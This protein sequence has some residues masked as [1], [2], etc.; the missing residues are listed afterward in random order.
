[1]ST[2]DAF[3]VSHTGDPHCQDGIELVGHNRFRHTDF[4]VSH[5]TQVMRRR[6]CFCGESDGWDMSA[7]SGLMLA[8]SGGNGMSI[9]VWR[10]TI[11]DD[12]II[13]HAS[14]SI[15]GVAHALHHIDP[16]AAFQPVTLF[17]GPMCAHCCASVGQACPHPSLYEP[18]PWLFAQRSWVI[19][20][21]L[22]LTISA[23][24]PPFAAL[25]KD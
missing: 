1:M 3:R 24:T 4:H 9:Q 19:R 6:A 15:D 21:T 2:T 22:M 10:V 8:N 13:D 20:A 17:P 16:V 5:M 25:A 18:L 7:A 23:L 14:C 12:A 11:D